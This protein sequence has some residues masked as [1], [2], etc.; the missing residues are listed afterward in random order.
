MKSYRQLIKE[1]QDTLTN[2]ELDQPVKI[3]VC[4][5]LPENYYNVDGVIVPVDDS[6]KDD[7]K[8]GSPF[9]VIED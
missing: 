4:P 1:I 8:R 9:L 7:I 6:N 2:E 5:N 3:Y